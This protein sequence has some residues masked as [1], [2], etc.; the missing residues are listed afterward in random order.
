MP[1]IYHLTI[2]FTPP[3]L[4]LN[5]KIEQFFFNS[6]ILLF[7]SDFVQRS[8]QLLNVLNVLKLIYVLLV[9]FQKLVVF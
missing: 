1:S 5:T 8:M 2:T 9:L 4:F 3:I 6:G 7:V